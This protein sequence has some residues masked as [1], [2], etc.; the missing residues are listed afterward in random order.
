MREVVRLLRDVRESTMLLLLYEVT[1]RRHSRLKGLA[2]KLDMTVAGASEYVKAMEKEG[3]V[4]R[5]AGDYRATKKGVEFL[6][7]GF[8]ALR[9][10]VESSSRDIAIIDQTVALAT[11]DLREGERVGLFMEKGSLTARRKS[12]PSSGLTVAAAKR[13]DPV[14]VRD[15][16][17]IVD[18][19]PG[20]ISIARLT[21]KGGVD[22]ARAIVRRRKAHIVAVLDV[23]AK[24][25]AAKLA[26]K[27]GIEF[28]VVPGSIE[29]AQR[30]LDVLLLCPE[31]RVAEVVAA[32]EQANARSEDK[33]PYE[34]LSP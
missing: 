14:W 19:R 1:S 22:K 26:V 18:L 20:K 23:Q 7:D 9:A 29:A 8:R 10:F 28:A 11:E 30:G 13:G 24:A 15:L 33:I 12:S 25:I 32:I 31:D 34:T 5:V 2:E 17:G 3:L 27:P 4:R 6:Q 21:A 16:E